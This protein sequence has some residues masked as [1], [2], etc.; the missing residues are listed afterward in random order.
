MKLY[1]L[2]VTVFPHNLYPKWTL[3]KSFSP[4]SLFL[5]D[6]M[7]IVILWF[8]FREI[9]RS[10]QLERSILIIWT[11]KP[12]LQTIPTGKIY[13]RKILSKVSFW[14]RL[15]ISALHFFGILFR[16]RVLNVLFLLWVDCTNECC[17]NWT[18]Y[19][20]SNTI[21]SYW[22]LERACWIWSCKTLVTLSGS[23]GLSCFLQCPIFETKFWLVLTQSFHC[24]HLLLVCFP[25]GFKTSFC[26]WGA[27]YTPL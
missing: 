23:L 24:K 26:N 27:F 3:F 7:F 5:K 8:L 15:K 20:K 16:V 19:R 6:Y 17:I 9:W 10:Q 22:L 2:Y 1:V 12:L 21:G 25:A 13:L 11:L 14:G 4:S 18:C